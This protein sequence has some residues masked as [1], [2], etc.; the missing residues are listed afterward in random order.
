MD[1]KQLCVSNIRYRK[2]SVEQGSRVK[3]LL[4]YL[5]YRDSRDQSVK[6][7]AGRERWVDLG[8]GKSITEIA[9]KCDDYR[10][11]HVLIFSLVINPNPSL[12]ELLP[13]EQR[14]MFVKQLT[15]STMRDFFDA[16]GVD[17]GVEMSFVYHSRFTED[18]RHN[19]HTHIVLPGTYY[20]ADEG[21]RKPLYF[22]QRR[23]MDHVE[24]LHQVTQSNVVAMMERYI[25]PDWEQQA[26]RVQQVYENWA[27]S[28]Q[29]RHHDRGIDL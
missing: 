22:N 8:M 13:S 14:E 3:S 27:T 5:T 9:Q 17:T 26:D 4:G 2:P 11:Q 1:R 16:R 7:V 19:P 28:E 18:G 12:I 25:G 6:L 29:E 15:D 10:S 23:D 24:L 20:D 21:L